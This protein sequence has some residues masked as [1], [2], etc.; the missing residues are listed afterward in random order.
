MKSIVAAG[1]GVAVAVQGTMCR[2]MRK[3]LLFPICYCD[4]E[5][6]PWFQA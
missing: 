3:K 4:G 2:F 6:R 1:S 5:L